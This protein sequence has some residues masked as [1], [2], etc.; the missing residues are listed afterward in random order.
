M[1]ILNKT[2]ATLTET[3]EI[4]SKLEGKGELKNYL[5]KFTELKKDKALA[6]KKDI[7]NLNNHKIKEEN[8]VKI[9]DFL[10][11]D[12]EDVNKIF[13]D[14]SLNEEEINAITQIVKGY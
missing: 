10:P 14:V 8:I 4:V 1:T 2:P 7:E 5:K 13:T 3:Q 12:A 6:L 11:K 9:V